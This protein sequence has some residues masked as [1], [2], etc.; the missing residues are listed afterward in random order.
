[1]DFNI[2]STIQI[3]SEVVT[4]I[5]LE[6]FKTNLARIEDDPDR[7][8]GDSLSRDMEKHSLWNNMQRDENGKISADQRSVSNDPRMNMGI[9]QALAKN[10]NRNDRLL[11]F[12]LINQRLSQSCWSSLGLALG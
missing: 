3:W 5:Q 10:I 1:M 9:Y 4:A 7:K 2:F 6:K 11:N 12:Q 8:K